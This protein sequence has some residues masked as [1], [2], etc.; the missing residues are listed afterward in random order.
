MICD[1]CSKHDRTAILAMDETQAIDFA[2]YPMVED[3]STAEV[4]SDQVGMPLPC[5]QVNSKL[6]KQTF[7]PCAQA[8]GTLK[9]GSE[10][11]DLFSL[12][13]GKPECG[14]TYVPN[15]HLGLRDC[16]RL[17]LT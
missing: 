6:C 12:Y 5:S 13:V 17:M 16:C 3:V 14:R 2:D 8:V 10:P 7:V 9:S 4:A 11:A 15:S 1:L